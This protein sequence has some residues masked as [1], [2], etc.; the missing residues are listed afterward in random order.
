[1]KALVKFWVDARRCSVRLAKDRSGL[2]ATE[3]AFIVPLMLL[4]FFATVELSAG[5]AIDRKVTLVSRTLSDLVSQAT[6]VTDSDLENVFAASYGVLTP[7]PTNTVT[8]TIS[9]IYVN[10]AG[11]AKVQWS[12][13]ATVAQDGNTATATLTA[14]S[15]KKGDTITIRNGLKVP[16][17]YLILSEVTYKY[18]PGVGYFVAKIDLDDESYT[19]PR[20]STCVLYDT[21]SCPTF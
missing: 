12:K 3:F 15:R 9:E 17:T 8:A 6:K 13:A 16:N 7:Y 4:M 21:S 18:E 10:N 20:Q 14:S 11:V 5:I 19:R 2:A 1:M